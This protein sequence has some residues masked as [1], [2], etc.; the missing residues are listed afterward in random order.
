MGAVD[1]AAPVG[2]VSR[3]RCGS[4]YSTLHRRCGD[5]GLPAPASRRPV[6]PDAALSELMA[7]TAAGLREAVAPPAPAV[8]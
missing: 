1:P 8:G 7:R 2:A 5:G 3:A 4:S 6:D